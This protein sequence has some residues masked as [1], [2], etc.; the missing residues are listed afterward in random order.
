MID[1]FVRLAAAYPMRVPGCPPEIEAAFLRWV[2]GG[3]R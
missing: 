3:G 1:W 2:D